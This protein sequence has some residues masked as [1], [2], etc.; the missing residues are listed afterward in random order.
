MT[1]PLT[2]FAQASTAALIAEWA[3]IILVIGGIIG[4]L[5]VAV[6][7]AGVTIPPFIITILWIILAVV[8]GVV[9]I[10]FLAS[11]L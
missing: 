5:L 6:R 7:A 3:I 9:A 8:I 11:Y 10:K 2:I 4:V 1:S